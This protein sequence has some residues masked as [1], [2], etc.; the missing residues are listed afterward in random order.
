V[1]GPDNGLSLTDR[2]DATGTIRVWL[3]STETVTLTLEGLAEKVRP[4]PLS[5]D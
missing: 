2:A 5:D 3:V 1:A 4:A